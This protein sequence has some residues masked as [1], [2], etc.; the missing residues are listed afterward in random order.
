VFF[1]ISRNYAIFH[2]KNQQISEKP[3][4]LSLALSKLLRRF[5]RHRENGVAPRKATP[6]LGSKPFCANSVVKPAAVEKTPHCLAEAMSF[7][8]LDRAI[9]GGPTSIWLM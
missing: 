8:T 1:L 6:G 4:L 7:K 2:D 9:V 3:K 5:K